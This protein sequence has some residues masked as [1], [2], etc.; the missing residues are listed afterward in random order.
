MRSG[1]KQVSNIHTINPAVGGTNKTYYMMNNLTMFQFFHWYYP[2]DGSLWKHCAEQAD[3]LHK[4]GVTHVWLPPAYKSANG[5]HEPGYAVYDLFDLGEFDQKG[6]TA[7]KYGTK[8]QYLD[9]IKKLHEYKMQVLA[10]VVLNHKMGAD[11]AEMVKVKQVNPDNRNEIAESEEVIEAFTK[12][13]FPGRNG[14]YSNFIWD[15]HCFTGVSVT[16]NE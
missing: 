13:T 1:N 3:Y 11:E 4:L 8:D 6:S 9:C 14:K 12:F 7:T 5:M 10:D 2:N 16:S 15:W